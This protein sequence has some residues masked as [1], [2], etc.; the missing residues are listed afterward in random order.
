MKLNWVFLL[1]MCPTGM[2]AQE[3][4][5]STGSEPRPKKAYQYVGVQA[6]Q[7]LRQLFNFGGSTPAIV[8]PYLITYAVNSSGNGVGL[9]VGFGY[10]YNKFSSGDAIT[11]RESTISTF[12][13]RLGV[14]RKFNLGKR[15]FASYGLDF[16]VEN[17]SDKTETKFN[18]GQGVPPFVTTTESTVN[19]TGFGPRL[20]LNFNITEK[21]ILGTEAA[22]YYKSGD[23]TQKATSQPTTTSTTRSFN[24]AVPAVLFVVLKF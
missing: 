11:P 21:I 15:W 2:F 12:A 16:L 20:T 19:N 24:F 9:N 1:M 22:Y 18:Q 23:T 14:E 3:Q 5:P 10:N 17:S 13:M 7:L 8:N 6:N 4:T